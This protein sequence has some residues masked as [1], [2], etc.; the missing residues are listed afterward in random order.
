MAETLTHG[1]RPWRSTD[2]S[3]RAMAY[4]EH[5][6]A[7]Q[8]KE[9]RGVD[10]LPDWMRRPERLHSGMSFGTGWDAA[11]LHAASAATLAIIG[12]QKQARL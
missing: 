4:D 6:A 9:D 7:W 8:A 12:G 3:R 11:T 10:A 1:I 5:A 2:R